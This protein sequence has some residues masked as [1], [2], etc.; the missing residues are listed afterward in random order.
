[1]PSRVAPFAMIG[2]LIP[3]GVA[4]VAVAQNHIEIGIAIALSFLAGWATRAAVSISENR[5]LAYMRRDL[6]ISI[7]SGSGALILVLGI[8]R[9]Y[10]LDWHAAAVLTFAVAAGGLP[11]LTMLRRTAVNSAKKAIGAWQWVDSH[12]KADERMR[13]D[14]TP[15][16]R[17]DELQDLAK[18]LDDDPR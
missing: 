6:A 16:P 15:P 18:R 3:S 11:V 13:Y 4:G 7:L 14:K 5:S 9:E 1:M 2:T 8:V 12:R 17:N 10:Q